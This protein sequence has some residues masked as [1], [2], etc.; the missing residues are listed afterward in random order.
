LSQQIER[1]YRLAAVETITGVRRTKINEM[2]AAGAF[3]R[4]VP[5]SDGGRA[6]AWL[7]SELIAWQCARIA[8]RKS[9]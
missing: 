8:K 4:P 7:E 5:L 9:A 3:P 1:F 2:I 6:I